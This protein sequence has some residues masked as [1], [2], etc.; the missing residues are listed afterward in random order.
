MRLRKTRSDLLRLSTRTFGNTCSDDRRRRDSHQ[1]QALHEHHK[2][3]S[4]GRRTGGEGEASWTRQRAAHEDWQCLEGCARLCVMRGHL[5]APRQ[6]HDKLK[7]GPPFANGRRQR[8]N[9][10]KRMDRS[11]SEVMSHTV[12]KPKGSVGPFVGVTS[13]L[14]EFG[15]RSFC[16]HGSQRD[17]AVRFFLHRCS[18]CCRAHDSLDV[19]TLRNKR[20]V[21]IGQWKMKERS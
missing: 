20:S 18:R 3:R 9:S 8:S 14:L 11:R 2:S 12:E 7:H 16:D 21:S 6:Q 19:C 4:V 10:F 1:W 17:H 13:L 15:T 5:C